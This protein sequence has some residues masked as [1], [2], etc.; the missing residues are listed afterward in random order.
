MADCRSWDLNRRPSVRSA[1][2]RSETRLRGE[3][4]VDVHRH[5]VDP[6]SW[7]KLADGKD[8]IDPGTDIGRAG[9]VPEMEAKAFDLA[10]SLTAQ[11]YK[12]RLVG[13][14][15]KAGEDGPQGERCPASGIDRKLAEGKAVCLVDASRTAPTRMFWHRLGAAAVKSGLVWGGFFGLSAAQQERLQ[16]A[17]VNGRFDAAMSMKLG[18]DPGYCALPEG[19]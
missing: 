16:Q 7:S 12:P 1:E 14:R 3:H 5:R 18:T 2:D 15:D 9:L 17:I 19:D 13:V 10:A 11:A 6:A 4:Q 8:L